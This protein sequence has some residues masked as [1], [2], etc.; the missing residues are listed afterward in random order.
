MPPIFFNTVIIYLPPFGKPNNLAIVP[1]AYHTLF[2]S[3]ADS[4][5]REGTSVH[6]LEFT[7]AFPS[8]GPTSE[9]L[10]S[11]SYIFFLHFS[12]NNNDLKIRTINTNAYLK[13][14]SNKKQY[15]SKSMGLRLSK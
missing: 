4:A 3:F 2:L 8:F 1:G 6:L 11:L 10:H 7:V 9:F 5:N 15:L 14:K 12:F 13:I